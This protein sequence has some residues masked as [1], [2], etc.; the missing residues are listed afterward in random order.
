MKPLQGDKACALLSGSQQLPVSVR[1]VQADRWSPL[2][3]SASNLNAHSNPANEDDSETQTTFN[4]C[5]DPHCNVLL[6]S[7]K[8]K[9][10]SS[11]CK[12]H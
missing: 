11:T 7:Y 1:Q 10:N 8:T 12:Q 5:T 6:N 4:N 2:Q 3:L 9:T